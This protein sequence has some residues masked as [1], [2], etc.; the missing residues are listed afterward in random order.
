MMLIAGLKALALL[1]PPLSPA[2]AATDAGAVVLAASV[3]AGLAAREST[4]DSAAA[5]C[6]WATG[7]AGGCAATA[8]DGADFI[9]CSSASSA[10]TL[11]SSAAMRW[12]SV[13]EGADA[14]RADIG[15]ADSRLSGRTA[16]PSRVFLMDWGKVGRRGSYNITL[17]HYPP[18]IW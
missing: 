16:K 11:A 9:A 3:S 1:P 10:C 5:F 7:A 14:A 8:V 13:W 4:S 12:A 6:S 2:G 15:I 18:S 17:A